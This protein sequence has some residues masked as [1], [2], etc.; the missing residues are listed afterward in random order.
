[1]TVLFLSLCGIDDPYAASTIGVV[2]FNP[3][4]ISFW[5]RS[6]SYCQGGQPRACARSSARL[7]RNDAD[8]T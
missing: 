1:M 7:Y 4:R 8:Q 2:F 6:M 5:K 3:A